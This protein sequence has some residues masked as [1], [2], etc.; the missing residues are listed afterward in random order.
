M[1]L[2]KNKLRPRRKIIAIMIKINW[3]KVMEKAAI[4]IAEY[5]ISTCL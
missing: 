2:K 4:L 5:I 1:D 3:L